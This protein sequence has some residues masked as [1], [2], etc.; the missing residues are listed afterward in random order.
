MSSLPDSPVLW[1][2][3]PFLLYN[4]LYRLE[5]PIA[6]NSDIALW[7]EALVA[8]EAALLASPADQAPKMRRRIR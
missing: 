8:A 3:I 4:L 6:N 5:K 7:Y 2:A 1:L